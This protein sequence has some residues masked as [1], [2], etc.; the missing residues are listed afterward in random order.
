MNNFP[1]YFSWFEM[2]KFEKNQKKS[3]VY[4]DFR[5]KTTPEFNKF[6]SKKISK[7][8]MKLWCI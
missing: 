1:I 8:S 4:Y 3:L 7:I 6:F 2:G 5:D